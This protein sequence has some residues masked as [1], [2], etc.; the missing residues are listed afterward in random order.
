MENTSYISDISYM[1]ENWLYQ[2]KSIA[3]IEVLVNERNNEETVD[4]VGI[5]SRV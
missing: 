1:I 5:H 2:G 3:Q 4:S